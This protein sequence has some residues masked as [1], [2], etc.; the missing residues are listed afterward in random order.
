MLTFP[1]QL[2][3]CWWYRLLPWFGRALCSTQRS[4]FSYTV[5]Q[6]LFMTLVTSLTTEKLFLP[7]SPMASSLCYSIMVRSVN[8]ECMKVINS[9]RWSRNATAVK[10]QRPNTYL[11]R[12]ISA[13]M[14]D[15]SGLSRVWGYRIAI[16]QNKTN[17][18]V[19]SL[20]LSF[21]HLNSSLNPVMFHNVLCPCYFQS[22]YRPYI[23]KVQKLSSI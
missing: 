20:Y 2:S 8:Y 16:R 6:P 7:F 12:S 21:L 9:C 10:T 5:F 17:W 15:K 18:S 4:G 3:T 11:G 22:I 19:A 1:T 13:V 14:T 23:L